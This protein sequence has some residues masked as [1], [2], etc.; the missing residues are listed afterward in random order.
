M[1]AISTNNIKGMFGGETGDNDDIRAINT[2][3]K[4]TGDKELCTYIITP[5]ALLPSQQ[6]EK[7]I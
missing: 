7:D 3:G 2:E 4:R 1:P 5:H 6:H